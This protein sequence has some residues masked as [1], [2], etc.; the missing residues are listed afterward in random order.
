MQCKMTEIDEEVGFVKSR[1]EIEGFVRVYLNFQ[2][3]SFLENGGS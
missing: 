2:R 1:I 3:D